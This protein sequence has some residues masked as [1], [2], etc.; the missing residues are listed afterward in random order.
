[1]GEP[2]AVVN[3]SAPIRICDNGGWTDTWFSGHGRIFNI[4]VSPRVEVQVSVFAGAHGSDRVVV[5]AEN[6]GRRYVLRPGSGDPLIEA[7]V[8]VAGPPE[9]HAIEISIYSDA[10]PGA[11]TG[12]SAALAVALLGALD[13]LTPGRMT[14]SEIAAAAHRLEERAL[15]RQSGIQDQLCAAYG[16]INDIEMSRYPHATVSQL[17]IPDP[18]W[19]ELERRLSLVFLGRS[20]DSSNVHEQV[21]ARFGHQGEA[22]PGLDVLRTMAGRSRDA[23]LAGDL[24]ALGRTMIANTEAQAA[25]H[26]SLV[27]RDALAVIEVARAHGAL[28]WKVNGAG[29]EGG[30]LTLLNGW[31]ASRK[32]AMHDA[33]AGLD[34]RYR[35][36]PIRL[37]REGLRVWESR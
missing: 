19:W 8:D 10:P 5:H 21:I 6:F 15:G 33:I 7:A 23:L 17:R 18:L 25:L 26:P 24:P 31:D 27:G 12:T 22:S 36:I 1:V 2:V 37:S 28:G 32:R 9:G 13:R 29:G 11:S 16:G 3:S 34:P 20:H 4:G 35:C 14:P 30:S